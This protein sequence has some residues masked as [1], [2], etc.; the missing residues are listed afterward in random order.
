MRVEVSVPEIVT[1]SRDSDPAGESIEMIRLDCERWWEYL[2]EM[3]SPNCP[4]P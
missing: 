1:L 2:T 4:N 3:M